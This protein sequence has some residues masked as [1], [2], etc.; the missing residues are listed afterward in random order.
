MFEIIFGMLPLHK[1]YIIYSISCSLY[2]IVHLRRWEHAGLI[3]T[4][5][6]KQ[7]SEKRY[8]GVFRNSTNVR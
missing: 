8:K 4:E 2:Y 5:P 7:Q 3:L 6:Y 1:D